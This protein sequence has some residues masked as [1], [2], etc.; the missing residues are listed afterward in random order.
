MVSPMRAIIPRARDVAEAAMAASR[1][2]DANSKHPILKNQLVT[3]GAG[4]L[5]FAGHDLD[6]CLTA[7]CA[8][9]IE[10]HG[11]D[12]AL[13][14]RVAKLL[15]GLDPNATVM[16]ESAGDCVMLKSGRARYKLATLPA[17]DFPPPLAAGPDAAKFSLGADACRR[18]F[19]MPAAAIGTERTRFYL[20]GIFL[21]A[22]DGRLVGCATNGK[23]L[24][25]TSVELPA[26]E[27][28][29]TLARGVIV[30]GPACNVIAKL[31]GPVEIKVDD[32][33]IEA[34]HG[35][36]SFAS[37]LIGETFPNYKRVIPAPSSSRI[38]LATAELLP[39]LD[40]LA[41]LGTREESRGAV[42]LDWIQGGGLTLCLPDNPGAASDVVSATCSADGFIALDGAYLHDLIK[43]LRAE[44]IALD[45]SSCRSPVRIE[46]AGDDAVL[47]I[48]MPMSWRG[49]SP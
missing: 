47:A 30:P 8:A 39:A 18:L 13:D 24:I 5:S 43:A 34:T 41:A 15:A 42:G 7:A 27:N 19:A 26:L 4:A 1:I 29:D 28:A 6:R 14:G 36:R 21:A 40:R 46:V 3:A 32:R 49:R 23:Q 12:I 10:E 38:E 35:R 48:L 16:F 17:A 37:K 44:R 33:I 25:R 22:E 31:G 11:D 20:S 45:V 2:V 9:D